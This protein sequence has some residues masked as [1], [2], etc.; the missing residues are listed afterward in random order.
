MRLRE[1]PSVEI[2]NPRSMRSGLVDFKKVPKRP[3]E[4][5]P[6]AEHLTK[7]FTSL[8]DSLVSLSLDESVVFTPSVLAQ[9]GERGLGRLTELRLKKCFGC[10]QWGSVSLRDC[11]LRALPKCL[12]SL[13]IDQ[14]IWL[15]IEG[16]KRL[17]ETLKESDVQLTTLSARDLSACVASL[18]PFLPSSLRTLCLDRNKLI[19]TEGWQLLAKKMKED[20]CALKVLQLS[21]CDMSADHLVCLASSLPSTLEVLNISWNENLNEWGWSALGERMRLGELSSLRILRASGCMNTTSGVQ[22]FFPFLPCSLETLS[23]GDRG[24]L[25]VAGWQHLIGRFQAGGF[26]ELKYLDLSGNR[27][28]GA[29]LY[30]LPSTIQCL[31]LSSTWSLQEGGYSGLGESMRL[32]RLDRLKV[33]KMKDSSLNA[34]EARAFFPFLPASL[35]ILV[36][37]RNPDIGP[38]FGPNGWEALVKRLQT[39]GGLRALKYLTL[40]GNGTLSVNRDDDSGPLFEALPSSLETLILSECQVSE[41][42][43]SALGKKMQQGE[44]GALRR[45]D[46]CGCGLTNLKALRFF[47][48]LPMSLETLSLLRN[49]DEERRWKRLPPVFREKELAEV[50]KWWC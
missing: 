44:L 25:D 10:L 17:G 26:V 46:A 2:L 18:F 43:W 23:L 49:R 50:R 29:L 21:S 42:G 35:E 41:R 37:D 33:L 4:L 12:K 36:L 31:D 34:S 14:N 38:V 9:L 30:H 15:G 16:M 5:W 7:L 48:F 27:H 13:T 28:L 32:G 47:P 24:D 6:S 22:G 40:R 1:R 3:V 39:D 19:E 8:P 45:L 20:L 11:P